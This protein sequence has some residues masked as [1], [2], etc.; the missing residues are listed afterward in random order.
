M[1][2]EIEAR[3][4]HFV[5]NERQFHL[6]FLPTEQSNP[7]TRHLDRA[8]AAAAADGV[9][10]LLSVDRDIV[11]MARRVLAS[12]PFQALEN[13]LFASLAGGG[14]VVFSGCGATGRLSILLESI[15][16]QSL[17]DLAAARPDLADRLAPLQDRVLSIMTGGDYALVKSVESFE[18]Y[19]VF[20]RRQ[21]ADM[22][23][24]P[25]DTLVGTTEGGETSSVIGTV[26]AAAERGAAV[27]LLFNNPADILAARLERCRRVLANPSVTAIDLFCGPMA[28]AGS[29]RM[30]ATTAEQLVAGAALERALVRV[31]G[32]GAGCRLQGAGTRVQGSGTHTPLSRASSNQQEAAG[33][34]AQP[35][36]AALP[37]YADA[38]EAVLDALTADGAVAAMAAHIEFE[39]AL[40]RAGGLATY[41]A[42]R[43]ILDIFTDTTERTPT[44]MIPPFRKTDDAVSPP[45]WAYAKHLRLPASAAWEGA[46]LRPPRCLA[47][48]PADY[49]A[50]GA[51]EALCAAPPAIGPSEL[52]KFA[53][54]CED[55]ASRLSPRGSAAVLVLLG[56]EA[57]GP[58]AARL[59]AA[60][61]AA[62]APYGARREL[63]L[64]GAADPALPHQIAVPPRPSPLDLMARLAAKLALN[65][66]STGTMVRMGRVA[67]NWMSHVS[68][69]NKKLLDRG[70][71]LVAELR[72]LE[73]AQAAREIFAALDEAEHAPPGAPRISPV[74]RCLAATR[75][76]ELDATGLERR[77]RGAS[78]PRGQRAES[79]E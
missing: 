72:G 59:R 4:R 79:G 23:L 48:T 19:E 30:Q 29:T 67:G 40:Y 9:R 7:K 31:I 25:G 52:A 69:S 37:N 55:D 35:P 13:A 18:D 11:P 56:R 58:E 45:S 41:Y 16:R 61:A 34:S 46:L 75:R 15:W 43:A 32:Q 8:F 49:R 63:V 28:V 2:P 64:G 17:R 71:R 76:L 6:G 60:F 33:A 24:G 14:R 73:Y 42:D 26:E 21:A 20:G 51:P 53:I 62:A 66:I 50:M 68:V 5:E 70:I 77:G 22:G 3:A 57:T 10:L 65:T 74:Q 36:V 1:T 44:F 38:F 39:E 47:W 78:A 27:F 12:A 54:G